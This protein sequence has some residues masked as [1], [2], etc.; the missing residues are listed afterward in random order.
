MGSRNLVL[1]VVQDSQRPREA[2][3]RLHERML[4]LAL[5]RHLLVHAARHLLFEKRLRRRAI[6]GG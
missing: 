4:P 2:W 6:L 5:A 1:G 3:E